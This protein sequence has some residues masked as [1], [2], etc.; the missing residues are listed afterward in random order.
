MTTDTLLCIFSDAKE[1]M[2]QKQI[3]LFELRNSIKL[4]SKVLQESQN[5]S[6]I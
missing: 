2:Y 1:Y 3:L 6:V 4:N 5:T